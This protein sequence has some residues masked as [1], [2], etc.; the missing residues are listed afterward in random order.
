MQFRTVDFR[1]FTIIAALSE[2]IAALDGWTRRCV[3][4]LDMFSL[5]HKI[6]RAKSMFFFNDPLQLV[7]QDLFFGDDEALLT[8]LG[9]DFSRRSPAGA[10]GWGH[11]CCARRERHGPVAA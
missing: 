6:K 1:L 2:R 7:S 8:S 9:R 11:Q 5:Y 3:A 4:S 10:Q